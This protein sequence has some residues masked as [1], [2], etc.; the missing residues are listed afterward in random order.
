MVAHSQ[1]FTSVVEFAPVKTRSP[2]VDVEIIE[3]L[4]IAQAS[5]NVNSPTKLSKS[6][7]RSSLKA[8]TWDG[9]FAVIFSNI[10]GGVLLSNFLLQ[11][12]ANPM[13]IGMLCSVPMLVNLLQPLGA[14]ISERTTSRHWY[15]IWIFGPSRL[16]WLIL[17][18]G[19]AF[20]NWLHIPPHDLVICTLA[21]LLVTNVVGA[22]GSAN[23]LT[24][25]AVLV[26]QK[27]RGRYFG[28]RNSA[29]SLTTLL[30]VPILGVAV[31]V[32]PGGTIQGYGVILFLGVIIGLISLSCQFFM[33]DINPKEQAIKHSSKDTIIVSSS[34]AEEKQKSSLLELTSHLDPNFLKFLLYFGFWAFAV[35]IC[36]PF[37]SLYLLD[38]LKIDVS[39]VTI[40]SSLTSAATLVMMIVWGKLAD[41]IGNRPVLVFVGLLVGITPLLW[42]GLGS[43][44]VSVWFWF[45]LLHLFMGG[46]WAAIELCTNNLQMVVAPE[47]HQASYFAIAAAVSGVTGALGTTAGGFLAQYTHF[48]GL[49]TVFVLSAVLRL[50]A[51][52]PLIFVQEQ[53]SQSLVELMQAS[54]LNWRSLF[55]IKPQ[56]VAVPVSELELTADKSSL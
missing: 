43:D 22:L 21:I 14:F 20:N 48:G 7:I 18:I 45:P 6:V 40:Y 51:L 5:N 24:W 44:K 1:Q 41:R 16:L 50:A 23:W 55:S 46:T 2:L 29:I 12:G 42:L 49:T 56:L 27:L 10:T 32:C 54:M 4:I 13:E 35:N 34:G 33:A 15:N 25:M 19:I 30:C 31:S 52:L 9:I 37:F 3:D 53:R 11:L 47:R 17:V 28:V 38:N 26:P 39:W 36:T 8:S